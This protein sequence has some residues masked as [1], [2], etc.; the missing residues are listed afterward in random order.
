MAFGPGAA[1]GSYRIEALLGR[2]GMGAVYLARDE[3]LG[4]RVALKLLSPE[5]GD[6]SAFRDRFVSESRTA[7][8]LDHPHI[9]PIYE[10]G[11]IDGQPFIAMRYVEGT[12]LDHLLRESGAIDPDRAVRLVGQ[13]ADALDAA[14]RAGLIHR[15]VKPGN[16]LVGATTAGGDHA[17]LSDFGLTKSAAYAAGVTRTGQVVGTVDYVAPEQVEGRQIDHRVDVYSLGCVLFETLTGAPPYRRETEMAVLYAHVQ[18][19]VPSAHAVRPEVPEGLDAVIATAMAKDPDDRYASAGELARAAAAALAGVPAPVAAA[20]RGFLFADLRGYTDYVEHHG[21]DAAATLLDRYRRLVR[22]VVSRQQGAE[23]KTEGDSFYV[24]FPSASRAV[25]AALEIVAEAVRQSAATPDA[26]I[27]VGVGVHA[28]E[29]ADTAEG[30]VGS[31]V[32]LAARIC[33]Q[34]SASEVLVSDTVRGLTRTR[35]VASFQS[36]GTRRLKGIAEPMLLY[37]ATA[38]GA[39]AA[40]S[41]QSST[42]VG[43]LGSRIGG[44]RWPVVAAVGLAAGALGGLAILNLNGG[45]GGSPSPTPSGSGTGIG[46][47]VDGARII[48]SRQFPLGGAAC[49]EDAVEGKLFVLDPE[50]P[51]EAPYRLTH[52]SDLLEFDPA[53]SRDGSAIA[54]IG[55]TLRG[56][57]G[58]AIVEP[59]A[60]SVSMIAPPRETQGIN[61]FGATILSVAPDGS[62]VAHAEGDRIWITPRDGSGPQQVAGPIIE[63]PFEEEPPPP[64]SAVVD[65]VYRADGSLLILRHHFDRGTLALESMTP[66]GADVEPLGIEFGQPSAVGMALAPD[67]DRLAILVVENAAAA[68]VLVGLISEGG[69]S[70]VER[71]LAADVTLPKH[72]SFSPTGTQL[73]FHAG[74]PGREEIYLFDLEGGDTTQLTDDPDYSA[75]TP[76]WHEAPQSLVQARPEPAP[77][78]ARPFE[79]GR[80]VSGP[81][82]NDT[83][84]PPM[85]FT[86]GDGW[87]ARRSYVDGWSIV[88]PGEEGEVD[89]GRIQVG[90]QGP[91]DEAEPT[92]IGP[93]PS[94][95]IAWI[96]SR[97]D[98][99]VSEPAAINLGGHTGLTVDVVGRE[100]AACTDI[101]DFPR[102]VLLRF[103]DDTAFLAE[104][105]VLRLVALDVRGT[106]VTFQIYAFDGEIDAYWDEFAEPILA[107]ISFPED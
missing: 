31:A 68:A 66:D 79:L 26:P 61:G 67:D 107:T 71:E 100:G 97:S 41:R 9:V 70:F 73:A 29:T 96:Q 47:A 63:V 1:F 88:V 82:R 21:D 64:E 60:E 11:D 98:L 65:L 20:T 76:T 92:V 22:E 6:Q 12:D 8:S 106:T 43:R 87:F 33:S 95:L 84:Q 62:A 28:G 83:V 49:D 99:V 55:S 90:L 103:G 13:I 54:F 89:Y 32:N 14:H 2:G 16:I 104:D 56:P 19:E 57:G 80:L 94:D 38:P 15:D 39:V 52:G 59:T 81:Y 102:W 42:P 101:P 34:A 17:Y 75:C 48:F 7:A 10:A 18:A 86:V 77:G 85:A 74:E 37:R 58:I 91:C 46:V 72:P 27:R 36:V 3:R 23:V 25:S 51:S 44:R 24:L 35:Q 105:E 53:W 50:T 93:R 5:L 69:D 78:E 40:G 45:L 30:P 4:R